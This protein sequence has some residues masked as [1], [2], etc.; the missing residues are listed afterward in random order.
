MRPY[1]ERRKTH[2][3]DT[4]MSR[5]LHDDAMAGWDDEALYGLLRTFFTGGSGTTSIQL[6]NAAYLMLTTDG[7]KDAVAQGDERLT[8][9]FVEEALRLLPTNHFRIRMVAEDTELEDAHLHEG[10]AIAALIASGNRDE[11]RYP[12]PDR[13][14]LTRANGRQHLTF[15]VGIGACVGSGLAR[16]ILQ[17]ALARLVA[18]LD[19]LRLDPDAAVPALGGSM[20]RQITPLAVLFDAEQR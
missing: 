7:M 19:N 12:N 10:D 14:D 16:V 18:R 9:R 15:S 3:D 20:F 8:A 1:V 11:S 4:V 2:P 17:A 6:V 13:V 5:A